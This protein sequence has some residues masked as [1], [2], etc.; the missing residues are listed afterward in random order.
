MHSGRIVVVQQVSSAS[1][2]HT[3]TLIRCCSYDDECWG[4]FWWV[5][6]QLAVQIHQALFQVRSMQHPWRH[7]LYSS[8][9][10]CKGNWKDSFQVQ[11]WVEWRAVSKW[12]WRKG[13]GRQMRMRSWWLTS[14]AAAMAAGELSLN[15]RVCHQIYFSTNESALQST[16]LSKDS[17]LVEIGVRGGFGQTRSV[18][19]QMLISHVDI[20]WVFLDIQLKETVCSMDSAKVI[21]D[22][23]KVLNFESDFLKLNWRVRYPRV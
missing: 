16:L 17:V 18:E 20:S 19:C 12:G 3:C 7:A 9:I 15:V 13:R 11:L 6:G 14:S 8:G 1:S 23:S 21:G 22:L 10:F 2:I 5:D 4:G